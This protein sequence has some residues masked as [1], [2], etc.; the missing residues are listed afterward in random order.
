MVGGPKSPVKE[1]RSELFMQL[2][3]TYSWRVRFTLTRTFFG[4]SIILSLRWDR[5]LA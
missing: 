2:F 1:D 4:K 5:E 3:R